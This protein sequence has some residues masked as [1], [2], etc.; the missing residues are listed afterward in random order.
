MSVPYAE[1]G[2]PSGWRPRSWPRRRRPS[3]STTSGTTLTSAR[4]GWTLSAECGRLV[5]IIVSQVFVFYWVTAGSWRG[6]WASTEASHGAAEGLPHQVVRGQ[7]HVGHGYQ[8][9][10][11]VLCPH[12]FISSIGNKHRYYNTT[13]WHLTHSYFD[14]QYQYKMEE[15]LEELERKSGKEWWRNAL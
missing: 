3:T 4:P 6:F 9:L 12:S 13:C 7:D 5:V 15:D 1:N 11:R 10:C 2:V 8:H 14:N